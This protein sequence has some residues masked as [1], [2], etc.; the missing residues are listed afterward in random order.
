MRNSVLAAGPLDEPVPTGARSV[1]PRSAAPTSIEHA[2]AAALIAAHHYLGTLPKAV[3]RNFGLF[4]DGVLVA[5][6]CYGPCHSAKLPEGFLELRRLVKHP[7][8]EI[9]LSTF[10]SATLRTLKVEGVSAVVSWADPSAGHHGGIYQATNWIYTEPYSYNWNSH[11]RRPDGSIV[12][13]RAAFKM[14]GTSSK[15]K[16][17]ALNPSWTA[18]LPA[19]KLRYV[20]PLRM[21]KE[22]V[23]T[24]LKARA[25]P[26]PKPD[27]EE[28]PIR[29]S[30]ARR[31]DFKLTGVA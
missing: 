1:Q 16:V 28:R 19:M 8:Y 21:R 2:T 25:R 11:F 30:S 3:Q 6:A 14:F 13:H 20:M 26:Y 24:A 22:K 23:L 9:S 29:L 5:A 12:D 7:E 10:L 15:T 4:V 31:R 27:R 17:L 18:F